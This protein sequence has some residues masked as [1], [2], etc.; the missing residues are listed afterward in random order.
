MSTWAIHG[1]GLRALSETLKKRPGV[2]QTVLFGAT[3][4]A[5]GRDGAALERT[6][7][8]AT[9][10]MACRLERTDTGLEDVFIHLMNHAV[11]RTGFRK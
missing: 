5:S 10:G 7:R 4:H 11:D 2:D 8:E 3:L 6:L 1:E 9:A